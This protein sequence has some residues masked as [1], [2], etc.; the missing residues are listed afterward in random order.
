MSRYGHLSF[1]DSFQSHDKILIYFLK[2]KKKRKNL[3]QGNTGTKSWPQ[4]VNSYKHNLV[5]TDTAVIR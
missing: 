4:R 5:I 3:W 2:K 1:T